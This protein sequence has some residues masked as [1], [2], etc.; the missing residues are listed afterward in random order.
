MVGINLIFNTVRNPQPTGFS[1]CINKSIKPII[2]ALT[3]DGYTFNNALR[4]HKIMHYLSFQNSIMTSPNYI[5]FGRPIANFMNTI[6]P[7]DLNQRLDV[8]AYFYMICRN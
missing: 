4:I 6:N 3:D 8:E 2:Y 1:E 7:I 5:N